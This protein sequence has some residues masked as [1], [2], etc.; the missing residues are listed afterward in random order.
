M[1]AKEILEV[2]KGADYRE[3]LKAL[4]MFE[5]NYPED[6]AEMVVDDFMEDDDCTTIWDLHKHI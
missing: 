2:L 5:A 6:Y 1:K 3:V 4:V